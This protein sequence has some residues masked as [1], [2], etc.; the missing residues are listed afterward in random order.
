MKINDVHT[1]EIQIQGQVEDEDIYLTSPVR[2][3]IE[4]VGGTNTF[5]KLRTDQS[6]MVGFIRHLHGLGLVLI[7]MSCS[8]E[9]LQD[10][11]SLPSGDRQ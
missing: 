1:Y 3:T 10:N 6:G 5:I 11:G 9:N 4:P 2:F 7:S 8:M